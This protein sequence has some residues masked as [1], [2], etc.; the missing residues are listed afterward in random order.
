MTWAVVVA[1]LAAGAVVPVWLRRPSRTEGPR[2]RARSAH[3]RLLH[4]LETRDAPP[5]AVARARERLTTCGALL[6]TARHP[7]QLR[8]AEE[9]AD[10]G[11]RLLERDR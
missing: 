1:L 5:E 6:A 8:L 7:R 10:E 9:V 2:A 3:A 4:A 11:L